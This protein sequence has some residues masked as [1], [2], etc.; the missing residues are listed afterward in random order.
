MII[1]Y[2]RLL[3]HGM[4]ICERNLFDNYYYFTIMPKLRRFASILLYRT[5]ELVLVFE[6]T[7]IDYTKKNSR[8]L[9]FSNVK[10]RLVHHC[11]DGTFLRPLIFVYI[12]V[13]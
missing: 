12:S 9:E 5:K 10:E 4:Y 1:I 2:Y 8:P 6:L 7:R 13:M 3:S 11:F